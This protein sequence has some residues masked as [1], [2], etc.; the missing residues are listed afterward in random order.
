VPLHDVPH[1]FD[2]RGALFNEIQ[3]EREQSG[4]YRLH[5]PSFKGLPANDIKTVAAELI[6]KINAILEDGPITMGIPIGIRADGVS[7][8][9]VTTCSNTPVEITANVVADA[10]IAI[11]VTVVTLAELPQALRENKPE[12]FLQ[13][14]P[15]PT[16]VF[17]AVLFIISRSDGSMNSYV[18][19]LL[20]C[21]WGLGFLGLMRDYNVTFYSKISVAGKISNYLKLTKPKDG[22]HKG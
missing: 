9:L 13:L 14:P 1:D 20:S 16:V 10:H 11:E 12:I 17:S 19:D 7:V 21:V 18:I 3:V 2:K 15:L 6:D 22:N 4:S 5:S 8:T